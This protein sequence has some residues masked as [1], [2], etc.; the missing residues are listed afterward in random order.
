MLNS[1]L[2]SKARLWNVSGASRF[3]RARICNKEVLE[4]GREVGR[5]VP[6]LV[7][8]WPH[9]KPSYEQDLDAGAPGV[10][11]ERWFCNDQGS[12]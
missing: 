11:R 9:R 12:G 6:H 2:L 8:F 3:I 5:R 7:W 10:I 4:N 1:S